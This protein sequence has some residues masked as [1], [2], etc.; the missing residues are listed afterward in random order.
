MKIHCSCGNS[1]IDQSDDLKNKGHLISDTQW[2]TFWDA[3]D[4][5]VEQTGNSPEEKEKAI[6]QLRRLRYFKTS[7]ECDNCGTLYINDNNNELVSYSPQNE[8]YNAILDG[9]KS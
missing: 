5:A 4:H 1:I 3:I 2:L 9:S 6:M 7:W 8:R